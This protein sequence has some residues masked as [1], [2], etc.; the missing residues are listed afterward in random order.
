MKKIRLTMVDC[1]SIRLEY[2]G[3]LPHWFY[4]K[5]DVVLLKDVNRLMQEIYF[6][7]EKI[8]D[9]ISDSKDDNLSDTVKKLAKARKRIK[10][11]NSLL[12]VYWVS[13]LSRYTDPPNGNWFKKNMKEQAVKEKERKRLK[14]SLVEFSDFVDKMEALKQPYINGERK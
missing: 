6:E 10:D 11:L 4:F 13:D 14:M 8:Y 3:E 2:N 7:T 1:M 9:L 12:Y 5:D